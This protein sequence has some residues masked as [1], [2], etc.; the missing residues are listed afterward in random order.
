MGIVFTAGKYL[1]WGVVSVSVTNLLI[2][3]IMLVVFVLAL[4]IPF[5]RDRASQAPPSSD[6]KEGSS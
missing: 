5:P 3:V 6:H 1:S 2:V 4:L